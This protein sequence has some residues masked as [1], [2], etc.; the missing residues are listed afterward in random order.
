MQNVLVLMPCS[1][2]KIGR[3]DQ[4]FRLYNGPMWQTFRAHVG[5]FP[6]GNVFVLSGKFGFIGALEFIQPYDDVL[7]R[8][9]A[10]RMIARGVDAANDHHGA[11]T[12]K[13]ETGT[14]PADVVRP[15]LKR[16]RAPFDLVINAG[17][18]H[19]RGVF[20]AFIAE[21]QACGIVAA[22]AEVRRVAGGIGC[23]LQQ[24][25]RWLDE[26]NGKPAPAAPVE[27]DGFADALD[28][29]GR[30]INGTSGSAR[31]ARLALA[32]RLGEVRQ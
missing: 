15:Y 27:R 11:I 24:L 22:D 5:K 32:G 10:E 20:D 31:L 19:Y 2:R 7:T 1:G 21:F 3:A 28:A 25:A 30:K 16:E 9:K 14:A 12:N 29:L 23:Q 13:H 26:L 18:S 17:G 4:A 8:A 6:L